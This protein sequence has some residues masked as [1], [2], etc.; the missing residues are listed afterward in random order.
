[1][2]ISDWSSVLCSSDLISD[3][4]SGV[5]I[6]NS[7]R[8]DYPITLSSAIEPDNQYRL[9]Y[10]VAPVFDASQHVAFVLGLAGVH[11]QLSGAQVS[12]MG[13]R[14]RAACERIT[15]RSEEHTSEL[16]SLMRKS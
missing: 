9:A 1:M 13:K 8:N 15:G 16:Q 14:L 11:R 7:D 5:S 10:V 6:L 12:Q 2:R 3:Y 4:P